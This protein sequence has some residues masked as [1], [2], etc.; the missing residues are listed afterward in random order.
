MA[1]VA[2]VY[3]S[4]YGH[5]EVQAKH[6]YKG[7]NLV[8]GVEAVLYKVQDITEKPETLNDFDGII[9]GCPTYMGSVSAP[10]K[11]F[12]DATSSLWFKQS[13]KDKISAGFTNSGSMGG[14]KFNTLVQLANFAAQH[15]MLWVPLGLLSESMDLKIPA[16]DPESIN[17]VGSYLGATAQSDNVAPDKAPPSGDLKTAELFGVR[18]AEIVL[19]W[20]R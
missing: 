4:G 6:V 12:M 10:F 16:G 3:H 7:A 17:R 1:K 20:V 11:A 13:W 5:T 8:D 19:K 18:V 15:S 14:D 9:F 2:V